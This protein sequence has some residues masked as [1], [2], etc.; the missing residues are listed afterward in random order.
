MFVDLKDVLDAIR[1][2]GKWGTSATD[3]FQ[4]AVLSK[5]KRFMSL[6][7]QAKALSDAIDLLEP[8]VKHMSIEEFTEQYHEVANVSA[9]MDKLLATK[10]DYAFGKY[11]LL[12]TMQQ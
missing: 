12:K 9:K 7:A 5:T 2:E 8:N 4:A 3:A 10:V 11:Q 6:S 1:S